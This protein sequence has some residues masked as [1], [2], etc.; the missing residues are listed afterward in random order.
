MWK[1][2]GLVCVGGGGV[3]EECGGGLG[4]RA[5]IRSMGLDEQ[6]GRHGWQTDELVNMK[7][8]RWRGHE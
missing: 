3:G 6:R 4:R 2:G 7:R 1:Q 8:Q 5:E